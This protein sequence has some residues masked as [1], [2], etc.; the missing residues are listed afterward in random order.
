MRKIVFSGGVL[1]L[2][3]V[4][5]GLVVG[6][7]PVNIWSDILGLFVERKSNTF[8]KIVPTEGTD[9]QM[10]LVTFIG[11]ALITLSKMKFKKIK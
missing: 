4:G 3:Y 5:L 8:Y 6:L 11:L 1:C 10:T 7:L 9:Y 2:L